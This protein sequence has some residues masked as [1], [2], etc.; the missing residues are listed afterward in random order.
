MR[1]KNAIR[2]IMTNL[3][4]Q[5][6]IIIYGFV[7]PKIIIE[8]FGSDVNGLVASITQF[9]SYI[10]F[11]ESGFGAVVKAVFYKPIANKDMQ[12]IASVIKTSEKFFRRIAL[13]FVLYTIV[14]CFVFPLITKADFD[15]IF[16]ISLVVVI[17]ISTFAEYFFGMAYRL[18]LQAEQKIY[19]VS[20]IQMITYI[21]GVIVVV[22]MALLGASVVAIELVVGLIFALRPILQNF[23]VK[24]KYN[25]N[26]EDATSSYPIKQKWDGLAQHIAWMIHGN[27]DVA[28]LTV[29]TNLAEVSVYS[30]YHLVV[31]AIKKIIQSFNNGVDAS[32]GDMIAKKE[33]ENLRKKFS[34]YELLFMMIVTIVFTS[35]LLLITSFISVYVKGVTDA[36]YIRPLFGYLLVLGEYIW[37]IR[38]PYN[39]LIQAAGRFKETR[40]GA[41]IEAGVNIILSAI[42]VFNFG[43]VGVAIGT[44]V[45]MFIRTVEFIYYANK[46][47]LYRNVRCSVLKIMVSVIITVVVSFLGLCIVKAPLPDNYVDWI[48]QAV[49]AFLIISSI[50]MLSYCVLYRKEMNDVLKVF[51]RLFKRKRS[52]IGDGKI[53]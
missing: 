9:L 18:F 11:F 19:V 33:D 22:V 28:V 40:K 29:F 34:V 46:Y 31:V 45:A 25:L 53:E 14:L 39:S 20:L 24:K 32:F 6:V 7:V 43:L 12:S 30:V 44:A 35:T 51:G 21:L 50:T 3:L 36:D 52:E 17:A 37:A 10:T 38:I 16:T 23:Y 4:L 27:T 1:T 49:I 41:W 8:K 48:I 5:F 42:L 15:A 26:F 2:N 47:I 13:S